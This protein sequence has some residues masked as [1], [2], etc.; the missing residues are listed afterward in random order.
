[1]VKAGSFTD[2][3]FPNNETLFDDANVDVLVFRY[4]KGVYTSHANINTKRMFCNIKNGIITFSDEEKKGSSINEHFDIY[5][6]IV[7]G[8]DEVYLHKAG[9]L[10]VLTDKDTIKKFIFTDTFPT[11]NQL[12]NTHLL[13]NKQALLSRK[14]K[15]FNEKNWFEWG[16]PR[17][18]KKIESH[19]GKTCIYVRNMTRK[20][21]VAFIGKV[22]QFGGS[23]L[24]LIPKETTS[25][26]QV[27]TTLEYLNTDEFKK[28]YM[29]A[30]RF[31]I[32]HKQVSNVIVSFT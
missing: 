9:N 5:V 10:D 12:I 30:G 14:I 11:T 23:L 29:Y 22:Q 18:M 26:E 2:F 20:A 16:A 1:M 21:E 6:G 24:S 3:L 4:E 7:S 31:K 19:L 17:N 32:G 28:D 27:I 25:D 13:A 15:K 8:K